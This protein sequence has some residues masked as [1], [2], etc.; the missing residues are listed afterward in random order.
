MKDLKNV[1][2]VV[3][4]SLQNLILDHFFREQKG[5]TVSTVNS[6]FI[7]HCRHACVWLVQHTYSNTKCVLHSPVGP[8][9]SLWPLK[10]LP[11]RLSEVFLEIQLR[12]NEP[13][14]LK[15]LVSRRLMYMVIEF[16]HFHKKIH[17]V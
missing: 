8:K 4:A 12:L 1:A 16:T 15:N 9:A 14:T 3:P 2:T 13:T 10:A 6:I 11:V 7:S 17:L 5:A